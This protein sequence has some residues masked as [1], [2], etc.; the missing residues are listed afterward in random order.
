MWHRG[1][2][3][4]KSFFSHRILQTKLKRISCVFFLGRAIEVQ[5]YLRRTQYMT[6]C[7]GMTCG[8]LAIHASIVNGNPAL[9]QQILA[10][11]HKDPRKTLEPIPDSST[12]G[13]PGGDRRDSSSKP[14]RSRKSSLRAKSGPVPLMTDD[15]LK[16]II[17]RAL[18]EVGRLLCYLCIPTWS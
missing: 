10:G 2:F 13:K 16:E 15:A 8:H 14:S 6:I 18:N 4:E 3:I 1:E 7:G 9:T 12:N 5:T 11:D 17:E